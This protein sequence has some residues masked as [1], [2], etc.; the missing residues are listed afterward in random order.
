MISTTILATDLK[1]GSMRGRR[2]RVTKRLVRPSGEIW[3][4]VATHG[5]GSTVETFK[6]DEY[7]R[8][9]VKAEANA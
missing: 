9:Y 7:V 2:Q 6:P 3:V 5:G 4:K 8:V 1:V